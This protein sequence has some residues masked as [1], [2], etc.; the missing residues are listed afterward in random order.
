MF[1]NQT[2]HKP[3]GGIQLVLV[4][5]FFQLPP[6]GLGNYGKGFAFQAQAWM[7]CGTRAFVFKEVVRQR[8]DQA[9]VAVL[10]DIRMGKCSDRTRLKLNSCCTSRK[11][12]PKDGI[13][14]TK[15]Y[16]TNR[17]VDT[18]NMLKLQKLPGQAHVFNAEDEFIGSPSERKQ[19]ADVMGKKIAQHLHLKLDAQVVLLR[20][21]PTLGLV[22]GSRGVVMDFEDSFP[23]VRFD[24]GVMHTVKPASYK[25]KGGAGSMTRWQLPLKL[26]WALT[27]HKAQGMTLSRAELMLSDCFEYGQ[28]YVALSRVTSLSGLWL[29]GDGVQPSAVK[30]HPDVKEFYAAEFR[31]RVRLARVQKAAKMSAAAL[32]GKNSPASTPAIDIK[33]VCL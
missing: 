33:K 10:N 7:A 11:P 3:F 15:L 21:E 27:I 1:A 16:S 17:N 13:Y 12:A 30:A 14:P 28:A 19:L 29:T 26:A 32:S 9:F 5:D 4:G 18:E 2:T 22:N 31:E 6:V 25:S 24:G 20:N 23:K 8:N